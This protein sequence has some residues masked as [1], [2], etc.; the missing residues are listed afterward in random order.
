MNLPYWTQLDGKKYIYHQ[1]PLHHRSQM[2]NRASLSSLHQQL[3]YDLRIR[4]RWRPHQMMLPGQSHR[5][6]NKKHAIILSEWNHDEWHVKRFSHHCILWIV[7]TLLMP[8]ES[9]QMRVS[10]DQNLFLLLRQF[11]PND[12]DSN[13]SVEIPSV[14]IHCEW[15]ALIK[16][17]AVK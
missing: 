17:P 11:N 3:C 10:R 1:A 9:S 2:R 15:I 8:P 6:C 5:L 14:A 13:M 7:V 12:S 16:R 4:Y